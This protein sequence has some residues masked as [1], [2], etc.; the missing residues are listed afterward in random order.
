MTELRSDFSGIDDKDH[1]A[2]QNFLVEMNDRGYGRE[3]AL[4]AWQWFRDGWDNRSVPIT[5]DTIADK[6]WRRGFVHLTVDGDGLLSLW[7]EEQNHPGYVKLTL[8]SSQIRAL[9]TAMMA[10]L[11]LAPKP[12]Q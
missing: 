6:T 7:D 1:S 5:G 10:A 8:E 3:E 4:C 11:T 12:P 9:A 2:W